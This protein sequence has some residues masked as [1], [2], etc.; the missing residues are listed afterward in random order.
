[1]KTKDKIKQAA[2][3]LFNKKGFTNVTLREV[4]KELQISYGN[5]TYHYKTKYDLILGLYEDM[6]IETREIL[7]AFNPGNLFLGILEAPKYTFQISMKYLFLYVDYVEVRRQY[8]PLYLRVEQ[9]N[10]LRKE[11][12]L[13]VLQLLQSQGVLRADLT[14]SDLNYLMDLSGGMR[15][16]FFINL[17]PEQFSESDLEERY[18]TYVNQLVYPYL[19][20]KGVELY[21]LFNERRE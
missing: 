20:K 16:F 18:I 15:T 8:H 11:Q 17:L 19:S 4:A 9:D 21:K 10:S 5:V 13:Q 7:T 6:L 12:Y 14:K 3:E 2:L 1:M